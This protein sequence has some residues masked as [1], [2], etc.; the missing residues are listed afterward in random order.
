MLGM[1]AS[2]LLFSSYY[3]SGILVVLWMMITPLFMFQNIIGMFKTALPMLSFLLFI[4]LNYDFDLS[5][6]ATLI[7]YLSPYLSYIL[8]SPKSRLNDA[9]ILSHTTYILLINLFEI[10][11]LQI[12]KVYVMLCIYMLLFPKH[13]YILIKQ[14]VQTL[15]HKK[16]A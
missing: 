9:V 7:L 12:I 4:S 2:I 3:I 5:L 10:P 11:F 1:I 13:V 15:F 8:A 6:I 14:R 16:K